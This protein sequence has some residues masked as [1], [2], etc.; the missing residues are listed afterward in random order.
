MELISKTTLTEQFMSLGVVR[1]IRIDDGPQRVRCGLVNVMSFTGFRGGSLR[2]FS[3]VS[4]VQPG[5][6][7]FEGSSS[8]KVK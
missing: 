5:P 4:S 2:G 3:G 1:Q 6:D 7:G 8:Q